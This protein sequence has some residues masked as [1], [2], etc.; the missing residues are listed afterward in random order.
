MQKKIVTT[1]NNT[2]NK[3]KK[4]TYNSKSK[5]YHDY[6]NK[7]IKILKFEVSSNFMKNFWSLSYGSLYP[8]MGYIYAVLKV[9]FKMMFHIKK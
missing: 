6:E 1:T 2:I 7:F 4:A 5:K 8:C 3:A 9:E